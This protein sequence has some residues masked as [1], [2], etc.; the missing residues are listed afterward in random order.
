MCKVK[1]K[2]NSFFLSLLKQQPPKKK[3]LINISEDAHVL[4]AWKQPFAV[5][6][7]TFKTKATQCH[8]QNLPDHTRMHASTLT[9]RHEELLK[10]LS[11]MMLI[12]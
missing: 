1:K 2:K 6:G 10:H 7:I 11:N 8:T 5:I 3:S 4:W 12:I 9:P